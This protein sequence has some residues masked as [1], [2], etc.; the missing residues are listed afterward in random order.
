MACNA[1]SYATNSGNL[2]GVPTSYFKGN[3]LPAQAQLADLLTTTVIGTLVGKWQQ[4]AGTAIDI[5][6]GVEPLPRVVAAGDQQTAKMKRDARLAQCYNA[7][8]PLFAYKAR[9]LDGVWATA[10]F[11][12]NGSVPTLYDL[13]RAPADRPKT[14][15]VGTR[16]Y[17]TVKGGYVTDPSAPGNTFT[18]NAVGNGNSNEGHDYNVGNLTEAERLALLEYLKSL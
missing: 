18:F 1:I 15:N 6:F 17:D 12:H 10:P 4:L 16:N 2:Q 5:F 13:L 9:P 3:P 11:L 14:F 7:K 8:S